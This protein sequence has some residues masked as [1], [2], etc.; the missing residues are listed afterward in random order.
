MSIPHSCVEKAPELAYPVTV[1]L[2]GP[3][4]LLLNGTPAHIERESK[5]A[6]LLHCLA[7]ARPHRLPR[8]QLLDRL[9][10]TIEP[11][12]AGQSLNSLV[13][14]LNKLTAPFLNKIGVIVYEHGYYHLNSGAGVTVD[15]DQF[16]AWSTRGRQLLNSGNVLDGLRY[17][18]QALNLYNGDLSGDA[19]LATMFERERLRLVCLDLLAF[20]AD[21]YYKQDEPP[22]ALVYLQR[23]LTHDPCR[24]DAHRQAMRCHMQLNQRAQAL[25]QYHLCCQALLLEFD[26]TPE[27]ATTALFEQI[28]LS[29]AG[30]YTSEH[31]KV[32]L[33][34]RDK[35]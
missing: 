5:A 10:P 9:W 29:P 11:A 34:S 35:M 30:I 13:Y 28:R 25:R 23:L 22:K 8:T 6:H 32:P 12:L 4:Q 14:Q 26:A 20:L 2:L 15:L 16:E 7:L 3:F 18:M 33:Y 27:P 21:H 19:D 1:V 31:Y 17:C 24:E